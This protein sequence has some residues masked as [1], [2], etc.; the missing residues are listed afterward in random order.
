MSEITQHWL[1]NENFDLILK[2]LKEKYVHWANKPAFDGYFKWKYLD[3]A[4]QNSALLVKDN[5][6]VVALCGNIPFVLDYG[7]QSLKAGWISDFNVSETQQGKGL[8][9]LALSAVINNN[10]ATACL[11]ATKQAEIVYKKLGMLMDNSPHLYLFIVNKRRFKVAKTNSPIKKLAHHILNLFNNHKNIPEITPSISLAFDETERFN[12]SY[13]D[14]W[15]NNVIDNKLIAMRRYADNLNHFLAYPIPGT[16]AYIIK[17]NNTIL[18]HA[19]IRVET[20]VYG[21]KRGR[22][23]DLILPFNNNY[24][25]TMESCIRYLLQKMIN[26]DRV[27]YI[28]AIA[29]HPIQKKGYLNNHFI[30]RSTLNLWYIINNSKQPIEHQWVTSFLDKDNALRGAATGPF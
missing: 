28:E 3:K 5:G 9:K 22:I 26:K 4:E 18:G 2:F 30:D 20:D 21:L 12:E 13:N 11:I 27:D 19:L 14:Y 23:I 10:E 1:N 8:G 6:S 25:S 15:I 7:N 24:Y 29:S 17:N 16:T